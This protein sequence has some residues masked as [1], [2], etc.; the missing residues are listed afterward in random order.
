MKIIVLNPTCP[1]CGTIL[2]LSIELIEELSELEAKDDVVS[3]FRGNGGLHLEIAEDSVFPL[4]ILHEERAVTT[5]GWCKKC[6]HA[7]MAAISLD[8][9]RKMIDEER[10]QKR[11]K[12]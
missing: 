9:I 6:H 10:G 3:P 7:R 4:A 12:G 11:L 1:V 8:A 5:I 2:R